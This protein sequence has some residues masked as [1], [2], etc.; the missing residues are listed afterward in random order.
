M[1]LQA[2]L[3]SL[4]RQQEKDLLPE[5]HRQ[6]VGTSPCLDLGGIWK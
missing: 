1:A 5:K 2:R 6:A 4:R 3:S